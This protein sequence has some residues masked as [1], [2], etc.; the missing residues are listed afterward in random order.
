MRPMTPLS[1]THRF[2]ACACSRGPSTCA[3]AQQQQN[4]KTSASLRSTATLLASSCVEHISTSFARRASN[5]LSQ[6]AEQ[7]RCQFGY[8]VV[9][10]TWLTSSPVLIHKQPYP[11]QPVGKPYLYALTAVGYRV[12]ENLTTHNKRHSVFMSIPNNPADSSKHSTRPLSLSLANTP[13]G[14]TAGG[15]Q[16]CPSDTQA[17]RGTAVVRMILLVGLTGLLVGVTALLRAPP[18]RRH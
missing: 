12:E 1:P 3:T 2:L 17:R 6:A 11:H 18:R 8:M 10:R 15:G 7:I 16:R 14:G 4:S 9:S 13:R 5:L